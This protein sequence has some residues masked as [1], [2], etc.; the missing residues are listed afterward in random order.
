MTQPD[1]RD[2]EIQALRDRLSRLSEASLRITQDLD[3]N[4]VLQGVLDSARSLTGARY[5]VIALH[6]DEGVVEDFLSSG[7][8]TEESDYLWMLPG[9]PSYFAYL[10]GLP[11]ALR[12]P[13]LVSHF[14]SLGLPELSHPLEVGEKISFLGFPV[15]HGGE[16]VGS[17][18]LAEKERGREF[19]REDEETLALFASQAAMAIS[20]ARQHREERRART[21]LETLI[22]TS[23]V[24]VVV[25]DA[26][27]GMP[28]SLNREARRLVDILRNPDQAPEQLLEVMTFKR[29]DGREISLREFPIGEL[30]RI[31][32]TVQAEEI[33]MEVADGR[34]I[35]VLVNATPIR[36][37]SGEVDSMVVTLQDMAPLHELERMRAEFL[38]MVSHELRTPLTSIRGSATTVLES[39]SELDP[40]ELRQF[41]RIIVEQSDNM[42]DLIGDLLDVA[43]IETGTLPIGAEPTD[44]AALVDRARNTFL[45]G[46]GMHDLYI[47]VP[48]KLPM[49]LVDRRRIVQVVSN[50][51]SNAARNSPDGYVIGVSAVQDGIHIA[52][53]VTDEGRGIPEEHLPFLFKKFSHDKTDGQGGDTG[54]GLA[55]CKGIVEAHGGRIWAESKGAGLGTRF[56]F[57]IPT[58]EETVAAPDTPLTRAPDEAMR[59]EPILVVD[60]DPQTL[61]YIRSALSDSGYSPFVT[62]SAEEA[63]S[64]LVETR[65][66]LVLLDLMLPGADGIELM[67][68]ILA[69]AD[70]PVIF[71]SAYGRDQ[72]IAQAFD[73]GASDYIVKPFSP[74]EL[75][76]RVK[77]ALRK[78]N[79]AAQPEPSEPYLVGD[80]RIDHSERRVS[81]AGRQLKLTVTEYKLL[82]ELSVNR[83]RTVTHDQLLR[84][85]WPPYKSPDL[86]TLRTHIRRLRKKFGDDGSNPKYI[87]AEPRVGYRIARNSAS[88]EEQA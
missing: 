43:R 7:M 70:V 51:L 25:F 69:I 68:E 33:V 40:A 80:L 17:I 82:F 65:P 20:N 78:R 8:T 26:A 3:F 14:R 63:L 81:M 45:S 53:S 36:T 35:S 10:S 47:D 57:T 39:S 4:S 9:W 67:G 19:T 75:V 87:F 34:S 32:E 50:L 84:R 5:G 85:V 18:Y 52:V 62:A 61:M 60:D 37:D 1:S 42:R 11:A 13:D 59:R 44:V 79:V 76:A 86:R 48:T 71:V 83:G 31:G 28:R 58:V 56:T 24:G 64:L 49:V 29:A 38:G 77:A 46:G 6:N 41:L 15:R 23:P 22:D 12:V 54:L 30:L 21:D 73:K 55:I 74:T 16:R 72:V 27:T 66:H 2:Q 88:E